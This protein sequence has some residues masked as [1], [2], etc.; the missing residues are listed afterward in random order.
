MSAP[1]ASIDAQAMGGDERWIQK[2]VLD[3]MPDYPARPDIARMMHDI[4]MGVMDLFMRQGCVHLQIGKVYPYKQGLQES[5]YALLRGI[6][7]V[8]DPKG[9]INPGSLGLD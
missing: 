9:L 2:P 3:K 6:K 5:T 8:V 4:R 1:S 7:S